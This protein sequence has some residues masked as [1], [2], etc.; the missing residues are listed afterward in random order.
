MYLYW[1][2]NIIGRH[3]RVCMYS[4]YVQPYINYTCITFWRDSVF[5]CHQQVL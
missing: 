2:L 3:V 1:V 4:T 5:A